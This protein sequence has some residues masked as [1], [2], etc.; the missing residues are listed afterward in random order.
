MI[1]YPAIDVKEGQVVRLHQ[2]DPQQQTVY[3]P[4]P[5]AVA[6]R[7]QAQGARYLHVVNLDGAFNSNKAIWP[8]VEQMAQLGLTLQLGGGLRSAEDVATALKAGV[9]RAVIGTV[10]VENPDLVSELVQQHGAERIVVALDARDGKV[11]IRGWQDSSSW[12]ASELGLEMVKRGVHHALY[13]DISRDGGLGGVNIEATIALAHATGL[14]VIASGGVRSIEDV[15]AL[16]GGPVAGV[17]LGKAL[18][19]GLIDLAEA[20]RL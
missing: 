13:T 14:Q 18:Y 20:L 1:I 7:W 10:A 17:I 5:V 3:D 6:Q 19:E 9:A 8:M 4:S 2:G 11:A 16:R 15:K 12:T